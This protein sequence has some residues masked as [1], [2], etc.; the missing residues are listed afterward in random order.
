MLSIAASSPLSLLVGAKAP[1]SGRSAGVRMNSQADITCAWGTE[2]YANQYPPNAQW[3]RAAHD[4]TTSYDC[5]GNV[6][7]DQP[8]VQGYID[9]TPDVKAWATEPYG[10]P[11]ESA[12]TDFHWRAA[13]ATR[14]NIKVAVDGSQTAPSYGVPTGG[15][16]ADITCG[17]ATTPYG[18]QPESADTSF[19]WRAAK[20]A[21]GNIKVAVDG[22]QTA[23]SYGAP[24]G[25][26]PADITCG[27][28]TE[29]YG[30][31]G[32]PPAP[33]H[34]RATLDGTTSQ[35]CVG[36]VQLQDEVPP[37]GTGYEMSGAVVPTRG[38]SP[39]QMTEE[40]AKQRWLASR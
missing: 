34:Q 10:Q 36:N 5:R 24:T 31:Q 12:D 39:A 23:T 38:M 21:R 18:Q 17:W 33:F 14:G 25:G 8:G 37:V 3:Q 32:E 4:G 2:P 20:S 19:H 27:W 1:S 35:W 15:T 9:P 26:T 6:R 16:Q 13:K 30:R 28:A 11:P 29:P 7:V 22:S 40:Q